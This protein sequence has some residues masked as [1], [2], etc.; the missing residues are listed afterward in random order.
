MSPM[1]PRPNRTN[2]ATWPRRPSW[3]AGLPHPTLLAL[4]L[5]LA[6]GGPAAADDGRD[7][8]GRDN[9]YRTDVIFLVDLP[10][11]RAV[12]L[13][14]RLVGPRG[15]ARAMEG[16]ANTIVVHDTPRRLARFRALLEHLDT[17]GGARE[18][19]YV[20]PVIHL[21]PSAL[22]ALVRE[23]LEP[24]PDGVTLLLVPDDRSGQL[25]VRTTA[26]RYATIDRLA[27]RLD[28]P[29]HERQRAIRTV[30]APDR[31]LPL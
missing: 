4:A 20:R 26:R 22:A 15:E 11:A 2:R 28:V 9:T 5:L 25:V 10:P 8:D 16:R 30:P 7:R 21:E 29:A 18:R 12:A 14:E 31:E 6:L 17:P 24:L 3:L 13:W 1:N 23:V 19:L 27:R